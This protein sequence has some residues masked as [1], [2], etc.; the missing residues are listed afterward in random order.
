MT[1]ADNSVLFDAIGKA[2]NVLW[3]DHTAHGQDTKKCL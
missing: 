3:I 1:L 2:T